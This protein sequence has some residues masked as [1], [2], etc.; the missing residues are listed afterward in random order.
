M[1]LKQH[2]TALQLSYCHFLCHVCLVSSSVL[3][4]PRESKTSMALM[5][6]QAPPRPSCFL[7]V[8]SA[9]QEPDRHHVADDYSHPPPPYQVAL[10]PY[11]AAF[12]MPASNPLYL[13]PPPPPPAPSQVALS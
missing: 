8:A 10:P 2:I 6:H 4:M 7:H 3:C 9:S 13:H 5:G 12:D 11:S 1:G